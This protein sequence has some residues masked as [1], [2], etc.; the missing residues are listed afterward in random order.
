[1]NYYFIAASTPVLM[2]VVYFV[3]KRY[4]MKRLGEYDSSLATVDVSAEVVELT[5]E[6]KTA[7]K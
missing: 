2:L 1:M 5:S 6:E 3:L 7:L 4:S